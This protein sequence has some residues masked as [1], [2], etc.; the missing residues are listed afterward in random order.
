MYLFEFFQIFR[1]FIGTLETQFLP[2]EQFCIYVAPENT[3][4]FD[5]LRTFS[6]LKFLIWNFHWILNGK[7]NWDLLPH[8]VT[9]KS[10]AS[11]SCIIRAIDLSPGTLDL[12]SFLYKY[13]FV[14]LL[15]RIRESPWNMPQLCVKLSL[16]C[17]AKYILSVVEGIFFVLG[18]LRLHQA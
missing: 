12:K 3:F 13:R 10:I 18:P 16:M 17:S 8:P 15:R 4:I 7:G 6:W 2:H 5:N 11:F 14:L 1:D 9:Y